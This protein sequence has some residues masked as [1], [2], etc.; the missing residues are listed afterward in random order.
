MKHYIYTN[1]KHFSL[2][3]FTVKLG[4]SYYHTHNNL[5]M[6]DMGRENPQHTSER[7]GSLAYLVGPWAESI[8]INPGLLPSP[9]PGS[10]G[11]R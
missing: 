4:G 3:L 11:G 9:Q 7:V 8:K 10:G 6:N 5:T 2:T 1:T